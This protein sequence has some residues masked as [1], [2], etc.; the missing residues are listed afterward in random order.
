MRQPLSRRIINRL[1]HKLARFIPGSKARIFLHRLRGVKIAGNVF[2][3][4]DVYLE[5]EYPNQVEIHEGVEIAPRVLVLAH[6]CGTGKLI[7]Q[8][9]VYIGPSCTISAPGGKVVTVGEG[10]VIGAGSV[11]N[12]DVPPFT[13]VSGVPAAPVATVRKPANQAKCYDDFVSNLFPIRPS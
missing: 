13:L 1:L 2:I 8:K 5:N 4:D 11:V 7:I 6:F 9:N 12:A 3:G 10:S